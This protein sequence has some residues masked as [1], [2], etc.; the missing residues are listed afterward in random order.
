MPCLTEFDKWAYSEVPV[1]EMF[2][3]LHIMEQ[4]TEDMNLSEI[5]KFGH[6]YVSNSRTGPGATMYR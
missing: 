2:R 1:Y 3:L 5:I 4:I 6:G